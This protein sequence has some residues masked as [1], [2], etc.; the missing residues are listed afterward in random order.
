MEVAQLPK[1]FLHWLAWNIPRTQTSLRR[2]M[3]GEPR[4]DGPDEMRQGPTFF[5]NAGY[6]GQRPP[7]Q[8]RSTP[9]RSS[10]SLCI[11]NSM[12]PSKA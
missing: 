5:G 4:L 8:T 3:P 7:E 1:P 12:K 9:I 10:F 6:I 2:G 11:R